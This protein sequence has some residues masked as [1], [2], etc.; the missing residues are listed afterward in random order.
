ML[1]VPAAD[2]HRGTRTAPGHDAHHREPDEVF[3]ARAGGRALQSSR[4]H[5]NDLSDATLGVAHKVH[6]R[7]SA[8]IS[9]AP[10]PDPSP[11]HRSAPTTFRV[12]YSRAQNQRRARLDTDVELPVDDEES[13]STDS[14]T[15]PAEPVRDA[16]LRV[17][18]EARPAP[19]A[20]R[21]QRDIVTLGERSYRGYVPRLDRQRYVTSD[22]LSSRSRRRHA[23]IRPFSRDLRYRPGSGVCLP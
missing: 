4:G 13:A 18:R 12:E 10:N 1:S 15:R 9:K 8:L 2:W 3:G 17:D 16:C 11:A 5:R 7:Q 20:L 23:R 14:G 6:R 21:G 22:P 19:L